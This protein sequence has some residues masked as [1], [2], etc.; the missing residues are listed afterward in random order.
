MAA[1]GAE[2]PGGGPAAA[3]HRRRHLSNPL[4]KPLR[5]WGGEGETGR[6]GRRRGP[7]RAS[8][9]CARPQPIGAQREDAGAGALG[10]RA[11]DLGRATPPPP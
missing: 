8:G 7:P 10:R 5:E 11:L 3:S 6:R 1:A 9:A 2:K 4:R